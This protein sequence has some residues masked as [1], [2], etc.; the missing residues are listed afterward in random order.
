MF[1]GGLYSAAATPTQNFVRTG[2]TPTFKSLV[3]YRGIYLTMPRDVIGF[4]LYFMTYTYAHDK[5]STM[6]S[7]SSDEDILERGGWETATLSD[8]GNRLSVACAPGALASDAGYLWRSP[9]DNLYK[10]HMGLRDP[11]EKSFSAKRFLTSP[12]GLK[13]MALGALTQSAY[14]GVIMGCHKYDSILN[15]KE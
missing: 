2:E 8:L 13:A 10:I 5:L 11:A 4:G 15:T 14:E 3:W 1:G 9:L 6:L 12:R 7:A